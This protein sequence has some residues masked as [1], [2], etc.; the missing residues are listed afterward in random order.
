M[1]RSLREEVRGCLTVI[2]DSKRFA[3]TAYVAVRVREGHEV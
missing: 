3:L 1:R 2:G